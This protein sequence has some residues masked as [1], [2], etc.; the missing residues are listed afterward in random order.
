M[1]EPNAFYTKALTASVL[2]E[3]LVLVAQA[4]F[5]S[6][7][8]QL[9]INTGVGGL[10]FNLT[11][12]GSALPAHH[13]VAHYLEQVRGRDFLVPAKAFVRLRSDSNVKIEYATDDGIIGRFTLSLGDADRALRGI[14]ALRAQFNVTSYVDVV[15]TASPVVDQAAIQMRERSVADLQETMQKLADFLSNLSQREIEARRK[16]QD[17]SE[18]S[19]RGRLDALEKEYRERQ[20][21]LNRNKE[22]QDTEL[23]KQNKEL[24]ERISKFETR[25]SK[26]VRRA[27]ENTI[28]TALAE[29]ENVI[30]SS[31]T[32]QKRWW[33][34]IFAW[35]LLA[36]SGTLAVSMGSKIFVSNQMEWRL[37]APV[38]AGFLTFVLT[39]VYYLK[40]NDRWFREHAD[41]EF[42]AKTY[43]ADILRA[44]WL[45]ELITEWTKETREIL[46]AELLAAY[47]RNLFSD[48]RR[49]PISE[50]PMD[51]LTSFMKRATDVEF[52]KTGFSLR[53]LRPSSKERG[54]YPPTTVV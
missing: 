34:H 24:Q 48:T 53:G 49:T 19:L 45:A 21:E 31:G 36:L 27:L 13:E 26:Y 15:R 25:E 9:H 28:R 14:E 51:A 22:A 23:A 17:E 47:T 18:T 32:T 3:K 37:F 2:T 11:M 46:P 8:A 43:K 41:M 50:H 39:M 38:S 54:D 5:Q 12:S 35:L 1:P 16:L 44:S 20:A 42:W 52:G 30:L 10:D 40:W 7:P 29:T 4:V 6:D 33:V